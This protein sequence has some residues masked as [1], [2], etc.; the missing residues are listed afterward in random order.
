MNSK[1]PLA[2]ATTPEP[3]TQT[4]S[5][6]WLCFSN[7]K[8]NSTTMQG[9][10]KKMPTLSAES[11]PSNEQKG[12]EGRGFKGCGGGRGWTSSAT[13][14][15]G[16]SWPAGGFAVTFLG[17]FC[18]ILAIILV[19]FSNWRWH[20]TLRGSKFF[21]GLFIRLFIYLLPES[22]LFF[23]NIAFTRDSTFLSWFLFLL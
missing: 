4:F 15:N 11:N 13:F 10:G 18:P 2:L 21:L 16:G 3:F 12:G 1:T 5:F 20:P 17:Y 19:F 22:F 9:D 6:I 7:H 8:R 14:E 23:S